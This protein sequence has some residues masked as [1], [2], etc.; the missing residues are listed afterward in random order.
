MLHLSCVLHYCCLIFI[1]FFFVSISNST[2]WL[3]PLPTAVCMDINYLRLKKEREKENKAI[4][5]GSELPRRILYPA[6]NC[7][8]KSLWSCRHLLKNAPFLPAPHLPHCYWAGKYM[9]A[10]STVTH[11]LITRLLISTLNPFS[12]FYELYSHLS[13]ALIITLKQSQCQYY[14]PNYQWWY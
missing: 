3:E 8:T 5:S 10:L 4:S 14:L 7:T 12:T 11:K 13:I 1:F 9:Q 6:V 2:K